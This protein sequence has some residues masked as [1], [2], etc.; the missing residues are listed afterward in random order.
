M[1]GKGFATKQ[2]IGGNAHENWCLIR[3]LPFFIM[4]LRVIM[5]LRDMWEILMLL[6]DIVELVVAPRHIK[7]TLHF[8]DCKIVEHRHQ[9]QSTFPDFHLRPKHHYLE[10]YPELVRRFSPLIDV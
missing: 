4:S 7:E 1:V 5:T 8:L 2:T 10:H 9:L 3:L 6:K